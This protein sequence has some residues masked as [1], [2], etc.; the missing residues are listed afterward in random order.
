MKTLTQHGPLSWRVL[1]N[2][3]LCALYLCR[4][5]GPARA[6]ESER[7]S[8][9]NALA[10]QQL[11]CSAGYDPKSCLQHAAQLQAVLLRYPAAQPGP[12]SWVIVRSED[13][14]PFLLRLHLDQRSPAFTALE[15]RSTFLEEVLFLSDSERAPELERTFTTPLPQL[16]ALAVTHELSH[17]I[18]HEMDEAAANRIAQQLRAGR[19]A[20]CSQ[21]RGLTPILELGLH[22]NS[23]RLRP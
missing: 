6:A 23:P 1:R 12:W 14:Q 15:Q 22:R 7:A 3:L 19:K 18:C 5:A 16:L 11:F 13:W 21:A 20:D 17:A 2:S 4:L 10:A 8:Q 9:G